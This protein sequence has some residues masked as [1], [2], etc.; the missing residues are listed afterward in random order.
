MSVVEQNTEKHYLETVDRIDLF[1]RHLHACDSMMSGIHSCENEAC[2]P[3]LQEAQWRL[4]SFSFLL[5]PFYMEMLLKEVLCICVKR[6]P[7]VSSQSG[8]VVDRKKAK[9]LC[10]HK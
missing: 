3:D 1:Q 7:V 6:I 9:I 5:F 10:P 8:V 2:G 4:Q